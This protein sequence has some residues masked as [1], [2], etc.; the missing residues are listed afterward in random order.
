MAAQCACIH[1]HVSYSGRKGTFG[2]CA[3]IQ[4]IRVSCVTRIRKEYGDT[5]EIIFGNIIR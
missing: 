5:N 4:L 2:Q 1:V 3:C